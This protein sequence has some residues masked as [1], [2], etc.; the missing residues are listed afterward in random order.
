MGQVR[1]LTAHMPC[2]S[3]G[4][5]HSRRR[6]LGAAMLLLEGQRVPETAAACQDQAVAVQLAVL[7]VLA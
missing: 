7:H 1:G 2:G 3:C 5:A 6:T 4:R